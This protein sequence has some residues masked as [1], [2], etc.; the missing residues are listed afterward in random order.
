MEKEI[1]CLHT[2]MEIELQK[3][4]TME[5]DIV[6]LQLKEVERKNPIQS[7]QEVWLSGRQIAGEIGGIKSWLKEPIH[8]QAKKRLTDEK[9]AQIGDLGIEPLPVEQRSLNMSQ[10]WPSCYSTI[11]LYRVCAGAA[12]FYQSSAFPSHFWCKIELIKLTND[13]SSKRGPPSA[14]YHTHPSPIITTES[15]RMGSARKFSSDH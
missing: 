1:S 5:Q 12:N 2:L 7:L 4:A 8:A 9:R 10:S 6:F 13:S 14:T 11:G 3:F 15:E